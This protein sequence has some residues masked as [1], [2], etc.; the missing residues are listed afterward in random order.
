PQPATVPLRL[1]DPF[2]AEAARRYAFVRVVPTGMQAQNWE[3]V[4]V[5]A[6]TL[7][8]QTDA[9]YLA[10]LDPRAVDA[11]NAA[12]AQRLERGEHEPR[13]FYVLG[14]AASLDRARAGMDPARDLLER[15]DGRWVLAPGWRLQPSANSAP[16]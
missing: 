15:F 10:R 7:G 2:W 1:A 9:V 3:E 14:D 13:T 5:Y 6:A 16:R 4:A 12:V 11:V 8:L